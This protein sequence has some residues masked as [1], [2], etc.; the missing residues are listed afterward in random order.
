MST[1]YRWGILT[2]RSFVGAKDLSGVKFSF[3][4]LTR[5]DFRDCDLRN[6]CFDT[7]L[8]TSTRFDRANLE[9]ANFAH[10]WTGRTRRREWLM[11]T[12]GFCL[13]FLVS[14]VSAVVV[15]SVL[16]VGSQISAPT[17]LIHRLSLLGLLVASA[18][19]CARGWRAG[20]GLLVPVLMVVACRWAL[21]HSGSWREIGLIVFGLAAPVLLAS[22][23]AVFG[24]PSMWGGAAWALCWASALWWGAANESPAMT[25]L[26]IPSVAAAGLLLAVTAISVRRT[27][28]PARGFERLHAASRA[29]A[30]MGGTRFDGALLNHADFSDAR[31]T[32]A[33]FRLADCTA[34]RWPESL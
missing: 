34:V 17:A 9:G 3:S 26:I 19:F 4:D 15:T 30:R 12:T 6:A 5:A 20:M 8:L 33:S 18:S 2:G 1:D 28:S 21:P 22:V 31:L 10:A 7:A 32:A 27:V 25:L 14:F 16:A 23:T 13:G 29:L 11:R 24:K